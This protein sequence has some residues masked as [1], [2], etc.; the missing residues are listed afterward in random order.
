L[1]L[2]DADDSVYI[3]EA[4]MNAALAFIH[5]SLSSGQRVLVH[6]NQGQSR[7]PAI[8]LRYLGV[9]PDRLPGEFAEAE[10]AL[11]TI[12]PAYRPAAGVRGFLRTRWAKYPSSGS[13]T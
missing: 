2:I 5:E 11:L 13:P 8:G 9:D 6:C 3:P 10:A 4:I 12:Y 7:A 1:N